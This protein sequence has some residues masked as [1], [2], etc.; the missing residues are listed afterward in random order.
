M[1]DDYREARLRFAYIFPEFARP[2]FKLPKKE[3]VKKGNE[4]MD[5]ELFTKETIK[6]LT[7][8]QITTPRNSE[9]YKALVEDIE[10]YTEHALKLQLAMIRAESQL[11]NAKRRHRKA[12]SRIAKASQ[13]WAEAD[14]AVDEA[15][16]KLEK[17][18]GIV[19]KTYVTLR[20]GPHE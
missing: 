8:P 12:D 16:A 10:T 13:Q 2:D 4:P 14:R 20:G 19:R 18:L 9:Y 11:E 7:E 5:E 17:H 15:R 1:S 6:R 3:A